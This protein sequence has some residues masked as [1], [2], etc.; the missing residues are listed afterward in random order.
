MQQKRP[1]RA[2]QCSRGQDAPRIRFLFAAELGD[3]ITTVHVNEHGCLAGTM[4]G[5]VWFYGFENK[6]VEVLASF[7]DEGIRGLFMDEDSSY[8]V[9]NDQCKGWRMTQPHQQVGT[10]CFRSLDRKKHANRKTCPYAWLI[11]LC[12]F[13]D[14]LIRGECCTARAP[15]LQFQTL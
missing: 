13:S 7:S 11:G 10:V 5:S 1:D 8:A 4:H 15:H 9:L 12:P 2:R 3:P 6:E 14:N